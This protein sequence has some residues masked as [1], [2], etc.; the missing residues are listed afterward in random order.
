[1]AQKTYQRQKDTTPILPN[2]YGKL[3]PQ[4]I[5][6]EEAVLGALMLEKD[7]Y[8]V[9]SEII[10]AET[11]YKE[12]HQKIFLA[13]N[14]LIG[15]NQP[16]DILTIREELAKMGALEEVGGA[17][18]ITQLTTKVASAA[19]I[20]YHARILAQKYLARE[21]IRISSEIQKN[22]FDDQ[23]DV[24]ELMQEAEGMIFEVSQRNLKK[25]FTQIRPIIQEALTQIS[26]AAKRDDKLSGIPSGFH[27]LDQ[28]FFGWQK[29]DLIIIAARPAMGKTAFVLS[30]AKNMAVNYKK[31]I[32]VFSLEM[33]DIQLV[34]RL[35][36]NVTEID[37]KVI[38]SGKLTQN[39]WTMLNAGITKLQE[40]PIYIDDTPSLSIVE[41]RSKARRL[42]REHN[43]ECIIIDYLQLM[44][45]SGMMNNNT[46]REQEISLISRSLKGLAKEL[47]IPIIALSQLNRALEGRTGAAGK[48]PQ[49]A[50][51]RESG[52][53]EQDADIVCFIHRPEKYGITADSEGNSLI[54][55]A[56]IIVAKHRSGETKDVVLRFVD[57]YA[58]FTNLNE[59]STFD[60]EP[61][62]Q[63][64]G[65]RMNENDFEAATLPSPD[66]PFDSA[67]SNYVP[68]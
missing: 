22:A 40:A 36:M 39:D 19:H 2:E 26:N 3:P 6:L 45:A 1:M 62:Y 58:K 63:V 56:E 48:R 66:S 15:H 14:S 61:T 20:E 12:S 43:V 13:I 41:L 47:N 68:Y 23:K 54:G 49:L 59:G 67:P 42:V 31:P 18:Y 53:I 51:L 50:D 64:V 34:N 4:A 21:L 7:A 55:L 38:K 9:V 25:D 5:E 24:D 57:K 46:P 8:S 27:E 35:L 16:V 37:G 29:S 11:F 44:N 65:S 28:V 30:M 60:A 10:K 32:A 52:A 17:F 33:S